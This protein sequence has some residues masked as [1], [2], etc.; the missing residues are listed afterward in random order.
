MASFKDWAKK[1]KKTGLIGCLNLEFFD[2]IQAFLLVFAAKIIPS[3]TIP[4]ISH[5]QALTYPS[6]NLTVFQNRAEL[7]KSHMSRMELEE[8]VQEE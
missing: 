3:R 2:I 7:C 8:Q 5:A 4:C 6:T 1:K